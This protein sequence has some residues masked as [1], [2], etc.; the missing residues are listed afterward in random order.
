[1]TKDREGV[2]DDL[3]VF[4]SVGKLVLVEW[5]AMAPNKRRTPHENSLK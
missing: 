1:M 3:N 5:E 4:H 2:E